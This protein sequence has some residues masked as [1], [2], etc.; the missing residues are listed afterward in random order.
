MNASGM[1]HELVLPLS[2]SSLLHYLAASLTCGTHLEPKLL[3][4]ANTCNQVHD[5]CQTHSVPVSKWIAMVAKYCSDCNDCGC[6]LPY[7]LGSG[8]AGLEGS[9]GSLE[10][11]EAGRWEAQ[12]RSRKMR[13]FRR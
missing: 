1:S 5:S 13:L 7:V 11:E 3:L 12:M 9:G 4:L 2:P 6:S 8:E 10:M